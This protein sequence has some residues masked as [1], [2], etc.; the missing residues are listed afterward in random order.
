MSSCPI[1]CVIKERG[2][3]Y[4]TALPVPGHNGTIGIEVADS[5]LAYDLHEKAPLYAKS[6]G[7]PNCGS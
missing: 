1:I 2:K 6:H 7:F 4:E 3:Y 5:S